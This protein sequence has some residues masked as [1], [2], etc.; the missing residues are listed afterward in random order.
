[1]GEE[2]LWNPARLILRQTARFPTVRPSDLNQGR[3]KGASPARTAVLPLG[4]PSS[5]GSIPDVSWPGRRVAEEETSMIRTSRPPFGACIF[6]S[7]RS[8]PLFR[9]MHLRS[10]IIISSDH[11]G[12]GWSDLGTSTAGTNHG[13]RSQ[14]CVPR[15]H[16][17]YLPMRSKSGGRVWSH[18]LARVRRRAHTCG[19]WTHQIDSGRNT[20]EHAC[21][22]VRRAGGATQ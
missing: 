5:P 14:K 19:N 22:I 1:M 12:I 16:H 3:I 20:T 7:A 10:P 9:H 6:N 4:A 11:P 13:L 21:W 2:V 15:M 17:T 8:R 18:L